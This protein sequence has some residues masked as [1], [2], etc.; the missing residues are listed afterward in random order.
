MGRQ[1]PGHAL[2]WK[3]AGVAKRTEVVAGGVTPLL[4][5]NWQPPEPRMALLFI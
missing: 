4:V 1:K 5:K 2:A 3:G